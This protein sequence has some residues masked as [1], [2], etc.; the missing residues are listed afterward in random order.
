MNSKPVLLLYYYSKGVISKI[1]FIHFLL[2]FYVFLSYCAFMKFVLPT[3]TLKEVFKSIFF[4]Y[5]NSIKL[6]ET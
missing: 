1:F 3:D 6:H 2:F 5:E 4:F